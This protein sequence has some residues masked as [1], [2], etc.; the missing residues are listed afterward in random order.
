MRLLML[1]I[2]QKLQELIAQ[3]LYQNVFRQEE[4]L[5]QKGFAII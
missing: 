2:R 5:Y 4:F 3:I 1:P